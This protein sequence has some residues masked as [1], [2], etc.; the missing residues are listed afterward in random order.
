LEIAAVREGTVI[1]LAALVFWEPNCDEVILDVMK[2]QSLV[3]AACRKDTLKIFVLTK[4]IVMNLAQ[5]FWLHKV[6][7]SLGNWDGSSNAYCF[8][9]YL[10]D[11]VDDLGGIITEV[12]SVAQFLH[13]LQGSPIKQATK[14]C[15]TGFEKRKRF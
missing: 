9:T 7:C 8:I 15:V 11:G 2:L 12:Q 4:T 6:Q 14:T 10:N 5:V 13:S 3:I 1:L